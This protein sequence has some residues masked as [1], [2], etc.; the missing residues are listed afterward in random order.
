[1]TALGVDRGSV[2]ASEASK[3]KLGLSYCQMG[4]YYALDGA[5][6]GLLGDELGLFGAV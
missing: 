1:M 6:L 2:E 5:V 4:T 3:E